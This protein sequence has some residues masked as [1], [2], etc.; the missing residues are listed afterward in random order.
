MPAVRL[1]ASAPALLL[2][3]FALP[4]AP[5]RAQEPPPL[6]AIMRAHTPSAAC[7]AF[8]PE[9]RPACAA[10][11]TEYQK[12]VAALE[13]K[14]AEAAPA[15]ACRLHCDVLAEHWKLRDETKGWSVRAVRTMASGAWERRNAELASLEGRRR[16]LSEE[17]AAVAAELADLRKGR[18]VYFYEN[19]ETGEVAEHTERFEAE[20]PLRFAGE[21]RAPQLD[22]GRRRM[23]EREAR[24]AELDAQL[25]ALAR[26]PAPAPGAEAAA[27]AEAPPPDAAAERMIASL[28]ADHCSARE[29][30][31]W[32]AACRAGCGPSAAAR[33]APR[34]CAP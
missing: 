32:I 15:E 24:M 12:A 23:A 17:R 19:T 27:Q 4:A 16:A 21:R 31:D 7:S 26:E 1:E 22:G 10:R 25:Q 13:A 9:D 33:P 29:A 30:A 5:A 14:R 11:L 18:V 28:W 2:L 3:S 8:L 20:P 34:D 6:P